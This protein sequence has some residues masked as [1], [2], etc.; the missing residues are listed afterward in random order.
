MTRK[1]SST[2]VETTLASQLSNNATTM[3]VAA[4]TASSL[5]GG[6]T[7]TAGNV[8]QFTVAI[9]PDTANEEI[10][11]ITAISSDTFTVVRGRAGSSAIVHSGGAAV[12]HVLTSN[13]LD[14]YTSGVDN[15]VTLTGTQTLTNKTLTAPA[16]GTP[17]SGVLTNATGLP[18]TTG[19]TGTL[20]VANGGT[21]VTTSTGSGANVLGTSPTI[22][23]AT[24]TNPIVVSPEERTTV[25]ATAATGTVNYDASTQGVLYYTTNASGNWTLNIRGTS[26]ATLSSILAV[27][28][29]ITVTH[30]V[31]QGA[32]AY[33]NSAVQVDGSSVTP[34]WQGG[35]APTSG[36]ASSVD[37]Y[38]YTVVKT[39]STPTYTVFASQT[40]FA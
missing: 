27:G 6:V 31:T 19:V 29:A 10:V 37:A 24:V 18:L 32:T 7:L 4:G 28:D 38:V 39:A 1:Y 15:A 21:G 35:T 16:L 40:K 5:L 23:T 12:K 34:K 22:A 13:D 2:S 20:P 26:G 11:F 17:V 25:S 36:N 8:D 9:D 30:L 33:Y 3:V 14:F